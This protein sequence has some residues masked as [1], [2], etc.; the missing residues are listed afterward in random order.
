[1]KT[2]RL[3]SISLFT[4]LLLVVALAACTADDMKDVKSSSS[5]ITSS[6]IAPGN[7]NQPGESSGTGRIAEVSACNT[8][9]IALEDITPVGSNWEWVWSVQNPN[10]GNGNN[11]TV[12]N[13]SH[14]GMQFGS[15]FAWASV[16][17][18]AYSTD[19]VN[20]TSF[21]PSYQVD[22]S[23]TCM[24]TPVLKFDYGTSGTNPTYYKLVLNQ[25]YQTGYVPGYYKSGSRTGC[26]IFN[27]VGVGC[28][29][30]TGEG[31]IAGER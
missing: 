13:L 18:A 22:P 5:Q 12:Q 7:N 19:G 15:C 8:Y 17:G 28:P 26:C 24:T 14:W 23:Q 10:P 6:P 29:S 11:G 9:I 30:G 20:W 27:F 25:N 4:V 3:L 2:L 21:T 31:P 1:M 16:V